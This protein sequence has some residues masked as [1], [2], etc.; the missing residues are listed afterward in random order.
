MNLSTCF[1]IRHFKKFH[2]FVT[3]AAHEQPWLAW[4]SGLSTGLQTKRSL[5]Q[6][7][8]WVTWGR[9][10]GKQS[11]FLPHIDVSLPLSLPSPLSKK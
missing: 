1:R 9:V 11:M 10:R 7:Q 3:K 4:H 2:N 6:A 8:A 5:V